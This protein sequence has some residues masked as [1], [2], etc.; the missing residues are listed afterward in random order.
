MKNFLI[1]LLIALV[2]SATVTFDT[3]D[4]NALFN[5]PKD[6]FYKTRDFHKH[7]TNRSRPFL[8]GLKTMVTWII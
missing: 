3:E 4:L 8:I 1:I 2:A 6:L 7:L 5:K